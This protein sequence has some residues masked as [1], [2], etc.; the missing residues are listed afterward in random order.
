[1]SSVMTENPLWEWAPKAVSDGPS[2]P[3]SGRPSLGEGC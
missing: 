3:G 1:M 2:P